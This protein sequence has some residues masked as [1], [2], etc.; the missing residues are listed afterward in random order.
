MN[1]LTGFGIRSFRS[2]GDEPQ[3][4]EPLGKINLFVGQN[5]SG[6]SN[7]LRAALALKQALN[8]HKSGPRVQHGFVTSPTVTHIG[9]KKTNA[10][11]YLP[12][13]SVGEPHIQH[14]NNIVP[15]SQANR[16]V[17]VA[18]LSE[19]VRGFA[20]KQNRSPTWFEYDPNNNFE[21]LSPLPSSYY[22]ERQRTVAISTSHAWE[23][24]WRALTNMAGGGVKDWVTAIWSRL[25]PIAHIAI[26]DVYEIDAFRRL[27]APESDFN[28]Y[29]GSGLIKR[30]ASL[31]RPAADKLQDKEVFE[32]ICR[33][34]QVVLENKSARLEIPHDRSTILVEIDGRTLPIESLGTGLHEVIILAACATTVSD[35]IVCIEEP[36]IHLHPRLQ[37]KF[38]EYLASDTSNQ[39]LIATHS[40]SFLDCPQTTVF[41]VR[42]EGGSSIVT[43]CTTPTTRASI[44]FD[45]GYRASDI[46]QAN[47]I[48]WVEGPSDRIYIKYW[49]S[50]LAPEL[51]EGFD[52][53]IMFYGGRLLA[54]L[55]AEDPEIEEFISLRRL[56]RNVAI[57][58]DSDRR[59]KG[60]RINPTKSR[61]VSEFES[62]AGCAWVTKGRE[63]ENYIPNSDMVKALTS[64]YPKFSHIPAFGTFDRCFEFVQ[65]GK[66]GAVE[67]DKIRLAK[68]I[69]ALNPPT[70]ILD[71]DEKL[72]NLIR[73][74]RGA[75]HSKNN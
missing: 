39:Y 63:I 2:F 34:A 52:F 25:S 14:L 44:C 45:L 60:A 71:L 7:V 61:I 68:A 29:N 75:S 66:T 9:G 55:T 33:F 67:P 4:F 10:S 50:K 1:A 51:I 19:I 48:V 74:I 15:P 57:V 36:E 22:D 38:I 12:M 16:D 28:G 58:I 49:L 64:I 20:Q 5:N 13:Y 53:S 56:N 65:N 24:V 69:V 6:K 62:G 54:H 73:F 59:T 37:R 31:E 23:T 21:L 43:N 32:R 26:P 35:S 17:I 3:F 41:H 42:N 8:G 30:L 72:K 47:S 46:V 11:V 18:M 70:N 40:A 27:G